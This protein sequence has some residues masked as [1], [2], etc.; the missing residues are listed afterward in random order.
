MHQ[1]FENFLLLMKIE[2]LTKARM[3]TMH[4][5]RTTRYAPHATRCMCLLISYSLLSTCNIF[6]RH[7]DGA[8][9]VS[10]PSCQIWFHWYQSPLYTFFSYNT[11]TGDGPIQ[12]GDPVVD[13]TLFHLNGSPSKL[14]NFIS[15]NRPLVVFAGNPLSFS[16]IF[17][18]YFL[19]WF[20]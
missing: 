12:E 5:Q 14:S 8:V 15:S 4:A 9:H 10:A 1:L 3:P 19:W 2:P 11:L 18:F 17:L 20:Y 6:G 16:F 13:A 7:G